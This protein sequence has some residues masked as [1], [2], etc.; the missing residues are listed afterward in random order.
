MR[1]LRDPPYKRR[2]IVGY[3][4]ATLALVTVLLHT[5]VDAL[6]KLIL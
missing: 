1:A 5:V 6:L 2:R 3:Y 4:F